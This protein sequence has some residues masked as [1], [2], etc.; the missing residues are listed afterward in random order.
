MGGRLPSESV[1]GLRRNQWPA[2]LGL[3]SGGASVSSWRWPLP[4]SM[5]CLGLVALQQ[6]ADKAM[7]SG[8]EQQLE[9]RRYQAALAER[10]FNRVDPDNRLVAVELERRWEAAFDGGQSGGGRC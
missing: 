6:Q 9:R 5:R 10:Q 7:R 2:W 1:A 4:R 8:A 3:R